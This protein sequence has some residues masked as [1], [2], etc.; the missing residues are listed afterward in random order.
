MV[1]SNICSDIS[2]VTLRYTSVPHVH[3]LLKKYAFFL[4]QLGEQTCLQK[5]K[6]IQFNALM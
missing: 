3:P 2:V 6:Q 1:R 5:V 4:K